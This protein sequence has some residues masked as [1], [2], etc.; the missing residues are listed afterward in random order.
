METPAL[1]KEILF[2]GKGLKKA[3]FLGLLQDRSQP[4]FYFVP[5]YSHNQAGSTSLSQ[6]SPAQCGQ[7]LEPSVWQGGTGG[8]RLLANLK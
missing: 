1:V 5:Q 6:G 7:R 8:Q 2:R 3:T 4:L